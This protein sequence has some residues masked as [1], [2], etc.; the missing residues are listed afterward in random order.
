MRWVWLV[1]ALF[2]AAC[3]P[4]AV[5]GPSRSIYA[6][7]QRSA[8]YFQQETTTWDTY[9]WDNDAAIFRLNDGT[10]EGA[11]V[12]DRGY[13]WSLDNET[14]GDVIINVTVQ[15]KQGALGAAFGVMCR[16]DDDGNGYYFLISS[17]GQFSIAVATDDR[18]AL[19][20]LVPWQSSSAIQQGYQSNEIR[21]VCFENYLAMFVNDVFLAEAVDLEAEFPQ[22]QIGVTL[23]AVQETAWV[24]FDDILVRPARG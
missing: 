5:G 1:L 10:L 17:D 11:V 20:R 7:E 9:S 3:Q 23:A 16:A 14:R 6:G 18:N 13:I 24:R 8:S 19:F 4:R 12:A 2:L 22:G 21:A 15:Q